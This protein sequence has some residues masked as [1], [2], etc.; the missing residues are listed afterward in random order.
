MANVVEMVRAGDLDHRFYT[1]PGLFFYLL[2]PGIAALGPGRWDGGDPYLVSRGVVAMVGVLNVALVYCAAARPLGRGAGLVAA[3]LLA[4]SPL[5]VETSHQVRPD[6]LLEGFGIVALLTF[7]RL[8]A[9]LARRRPRGSRD[10]PRHRREV[11][12]PPDGPLL[13][14]HADPPPG[15]ARPRSSRGRRPGCARPCPRDS[16]LPHPRRAL[17]TWAG[18]PARHVLLLAAGAAVVRT[19]PRGVRGG[20]LA[21]A[22]F[23]GLPVGAP[24]RGH[25]LAWLVAGVAARR[26]FI[27]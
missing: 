27:R 9:R 11:Y 14:G 1:Y 4:A 8:G 10:R 21:R 24:G 2:A 18:S 26:S 6:V 16:L 19:K 22:G 17:P 25:A 23:G 12:R 13:P 7:R 20:G 5:D 3:S 15:S